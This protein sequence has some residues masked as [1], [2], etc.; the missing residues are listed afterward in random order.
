L[1]TSPANELKKRVLFTRIIAYQIKL[2]PVHNK[3]KKK[4]YFLTAF[5][6]P[7][8]FFFSSCKPFALVMSEN[9]LFQ[10]AQVIAELPLQDSSTNQQQQNESNSYSR[11]LRVRKVNINTNSTKKKKV[12][13]T[14]VKECLRCM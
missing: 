12:I 5:L 10:F 4:N 11:Y 13:L 2:V 7:S 3:K 6:S 14:A 9:N 8:F 1:K